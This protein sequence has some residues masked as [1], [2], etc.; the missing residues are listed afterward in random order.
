MGFVSIKK[1]MDLNQESM[2]LSENKIQANLIRSQQLNN[3]N[4]LLKNNL[5]KALNDSSPQQNKLKQLEQELIKIN[6]NNQNSSLH[7]INK[8]F[9]GVDFEL[10]QLIKKRNLLL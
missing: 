7:L 6:E 3:K 2:K 10:E 8:D 1:E 4:D 9:E 5:D